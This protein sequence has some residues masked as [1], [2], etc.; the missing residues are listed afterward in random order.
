MKLLEH[1]AKKKLTQDKTIELKPRQL[2]FSSTRPCKYLRFTNRSYCCDQPE[3]N[4]SDGIIVLNNSAVDEAM[5]TGESI[6][7]EK[8]V[9]SKVTRGT[10]RRTFGL[11]IVTL[12][13]C[14][15]GATSKLPIQKLVDKIAG[16]FVP[17]VVLIAFLTFITWLFIGGHN[18]FSVALVNFVAVLIIACPCA[19]GLATPTA[20][21]VGSGLGASHGILIRNGES[22]ELA[23]KI[24]TII[25]D[26]TGTITEGKPSVSEITTENITEDEL[27]LLSASLESKSEHPLGMAIVEKARSKDISL[28]QP[29]SFQNL[30][31]FG[32]TGIVKSRAVIIGNMNLMKEY[33][34]KM[35][36]MKEQFEKLVED[37]RTV[38]CIA[39]DGELKG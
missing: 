31:G 13:T 27:L 20:I 29:E 24:T 2:K 11:N 36:S 19:L 23:Q 1:S 38:V 3:K 39:I 35:E 18:S 32:L 7:S 17:I 14:R 5:I 34:I 22:L 37:G 16:V 21:I 4:S 9:G 8:T 26:K 30:S 25:F 12:L 6:P 10:I 28:L 15:T 33:S